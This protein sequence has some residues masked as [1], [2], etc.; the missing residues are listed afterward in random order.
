[1]GLHEIKKVMKNKR[2]SHQ[3]EQGVY[4]WYGIEE[5]LCQLYILQGINNQNIQGVQKMKLIPQN[6]LSNE[7]MGLIF[8]QS[9]SKE[10]SPSGQ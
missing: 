5:I 6:Q 3:T 1:M 8:G 7:E 9:F 10:K 4:Y 2:N